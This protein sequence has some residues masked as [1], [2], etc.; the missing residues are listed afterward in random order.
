MEKAEYTID[1]KTVLLNIPITLEYL[2][3]DV[4]NPSPVDV[5]E[6]WMKYNEKWIKEEKK[7]LLWNINEHEEYHDTFRHIMDMGNIPDDPIEIESDGEYDCYGYSVK[8][9]ELGEGMKRLIKES[10]LGRCIP[11]ENELEYERKIRR[12]SEEIEKIMAE[13]KK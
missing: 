11:G 13:R 8:W 7:P 1:T 4:P 5:V 12:E 3:S 10:W 9:S 6:R 2:K